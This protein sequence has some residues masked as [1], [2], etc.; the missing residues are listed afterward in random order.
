MKTERPRIPESAMAGRREG[1]REGRA[2]RV[3]ASEGRWG[4]KRGSGRL[5][6]AEK[7]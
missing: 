1:G 6:S 7:P 3:R 2:A 5:L 4:G